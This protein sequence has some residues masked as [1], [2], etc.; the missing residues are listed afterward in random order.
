MRLLAALVLAV[1]G[2]VAVPGAG[3][4]AQAPASSVGPVS[5]GSRAHPHGRWLLDPHG[6]VLVLHGVNMVY[7]LAPYAPRRGGLRPRRRAVP[8]PATA[9]PRCGSGSSGRAVEPQPGRVR[10]RLPRADR[11]HHADPRRRRHLVAA[12][13][14]PGPVQRALPGRGL[15]RLGGAGRRAARRAAGRGSPATTSDARRSTDAFDNFWANGPGPG[16][17]GLQDRYAAAWAHVAAYFR[18]TPASSAYDLFNEPWPGT[19]VAA[20]CEPGRLPGLRRE[21]AG[22][23]AAHDRRGPRGGPANDGLLRAAG[24]VH[25]RLADQLAPTGRRLGF[26]FHDYCITADAG[27][28]ESG[29]QQAC[30]QLDDQ[31]WRNAEAHVAAT[32]DAALLTE[33]GAT[34]GADAPAM[35]ARAAARRTGWQYWA[36]CGCDDPPPPVPAAPRPWSSTRPGRRAATTS[37]GRRCARSSSRTRSPCPGPPRRTGSIAAAGVPDVLVGGASGRRRTVRGQGSGRTISVPASVYRKGYV[38][39]VTG[40]RVVSKPGRPDPG[41]RAATPAP[42]GCSVVVRPR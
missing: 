28:S 25:R 13:L 22:L 20:V 40:G 41:G 12:R 38:V 2:L 9:S 19:G 1:A 35:V 24:P 31:V 14:P 4:S 32:G 17:V 5:P 39:T 21:A 36:Y 30:S 18:R 10:R 42:T 16:G 23:H 7:K 37:T 34:G 11:A 15:P 29:A 3:V 33:F 8:A 6:R 26:S 27:A